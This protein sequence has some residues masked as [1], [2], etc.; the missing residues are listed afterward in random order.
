[1]NHPDSRNHRSLEERRMRPRSVFVYLLLAGLLL[2]GIGVGILVMPQA[3][4]ASNGITLAEDPSLL[5]EV[6]AP[7]GM[8]TACAL[9]LLF[10]AFRPAREDVRLLALRLTVLVYGSFGLARLLGMALDGIPASGVVAAAVIE[11]VVAGLGLV[12]LSRQVVVKARRNGTT[13]ESV[14][15]SA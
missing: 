6:R 5:S 8:L 1:M 3:F 7:G 9:V 15:S 12:L 11:L 2:L 4:F 10:A 14:P 13:A